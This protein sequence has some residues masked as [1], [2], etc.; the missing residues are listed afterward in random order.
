MGRSP[1]TA[2]EA[3]VR[4][5]FGTRPS[6]TRGTGSGGERP[7]HSIPTAQLQGN[8]AAGPAARPDRL[9]Y[10]TLSLILLAGLAATS[11]YKAWTLSITIDEAY[12][13]LNYV[14]GPFS[15]VFTQP[16]Y[17]NHA[18]NTLL[19]KL[20][21]AVFGLSEFT[22]RLPSV[23][24]GWLYFMALFRLARLLFG[25][26]G[27]LLIAVTVNSLNPFV[28]DHLCSARGYGMG[29]AFWTLGAYYVVR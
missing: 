28:L 5:W 11:I 10:A 13:Y 8:A 27:W 12:T 6:P 9:V 25:H 15:A 4:L 19:C 20:A 16:G 21:V 24:C 18:L 3:P 1:W 29:L 22:L 17:N 7:A 2:T 23:L 26:S 14:S